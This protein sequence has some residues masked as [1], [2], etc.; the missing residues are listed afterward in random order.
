MY[1]VHR[2]PRSFSPYPDAF[3]PER[4]L[5]ADADRRSELKSPNFGSPTTI[6]PALSTAPLFTTAVEKKDYRHNSS[7]FVPFSIGPANCAG[8]N[9]ALMEMRM[10]IC[11]LIQRFEI[12]FAD[13][14]DCNEWDQSL[15]DIMVARIGELPLSFARRQ[16]AW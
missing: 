15:R 16:G 14:W 11:G 8:K 12:R 4:W 6:Q 5:L 1:T 2:D 13:G 7:A 10:V 3:W 9:L